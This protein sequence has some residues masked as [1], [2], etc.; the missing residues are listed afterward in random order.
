MFH[1][2]ANMF[3][4]GADMDSFILR[5]SNYFVQIWNYTLPL[6][7]RYQGL[8]LGKFGS[9][10][11]FF[12]VKYITSLSMI[13]IIMIF[14]EMPSK[15]AIVLVHPSVHLV[16]H[17]FYREIPWIPMY[18]HGLLCSQFW[19]GFS[20][21]YGFLGFYEFGQAYLIGDFGTAYLRGRD[22]RDFIFMQCI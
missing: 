13:L 6:D 5:I 4:F 3:N 16:I 18:I 17:A 1:F 15:Q 12:Q 19:L 7:S 2:R 22:S 9:G 8:P 21:I 10:A 11:V 20:G 14:H